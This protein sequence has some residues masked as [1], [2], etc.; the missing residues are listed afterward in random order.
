MGKILK[1]SLLAVFPRN[2]LYP[3]SIKKVRIS[4]YTV[5]LPCSSSAMILA[6]EEIFNVPVLLFQVF[7]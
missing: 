7:D 3:S 2:R 1:Y 6:R 4:L 5:K